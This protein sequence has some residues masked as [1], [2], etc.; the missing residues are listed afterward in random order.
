MSITVEP[1]ILQGFMELLPREQVVFNR[2][3][4][5]IREVYERFG[6]L[7]IDTPTIERSDVL[8]A[9]AGGETEKQ[10]YR[11]TKGDADLSLR[12]DLTVPLA[13][14]YANNKEK[15]P[16][17]FKAMQLGNVWRADNP[18][19]GRFR[20]QAEYIVWGSNGDMPISRPV[21]C[22]PGV[23]KYG[24]PQSRIH[25]TEKPLQLMRDIVKITEP[26]GHIL[27]PFAGSGTTVLAAVQEGYTA[28]GIEVMDAYAALAR[29]RIR[30]ALEDV[31]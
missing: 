30:Q 3:Y 28:T 10:I 16:T 22:L 24:N 18:Q 12:F 25:L 26:G 1:K 6:F 13:R 15:L 11:F 31:Q 19:K 21:P 5:K 8:L 27:D 2:I 29:G 20:Q 9:K 17:P 7:P 23:F 14:Y 4:D